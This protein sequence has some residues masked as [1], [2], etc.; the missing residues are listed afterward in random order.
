MSSTWSDILKEEKEKEYFKKV[1]AFQEGERRKSKNIYPAKE[2][3]FNAFKLT[4]FG[5]VKVVILGQDPYHGAGQA[6]GL[7]FSV[8]VGISPPPS[9]KNIFKELESDLSN[10]ENVL[11]SGFRIPK[12]G[13]LAYW[14]QQGVFLLNTVLTVEESKPGSHAG[15]GWETFTDFI[16]KSISDHKDHVVFLLW[17]N[18]A[19]SKASLIDSG[20]HTILLAPHPSPLSAYSGFFGCKHFSLCNKYLE[21][22]NQKPV[23]W[24]L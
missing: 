13:H 1:F 16:I 15:R 8:P 10:P 19:K 24:R 4:T 7:C 21:Q 9:L 20:K 11:E 18:Y 17:G 6:E 5:S 14:A 23:D 3:I 22:H 2:N 12:H